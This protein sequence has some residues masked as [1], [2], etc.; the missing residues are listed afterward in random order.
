M[1]SYL[2]IRCAVLATIVF[3]TGAWAGPGDLHW[4]SPPGKPYN[5]APGQLLPTEIDLKLQ[6]GTYYRRGSYQKKG[7]P[8]TQDGIVGIIKSSKNRRIQNETG[9]MGTIVVD[10]KE[11]IKANGNVRL[12]Y[13]QEDKYQNDF[14]LKEQAKHGLS[15]VSDAEG[16]SRTVHLG[17]D[18]ILDIEA[19]NKLS[20]LAGIY[21]G[22]GG[23]VTYSRISLTGTETGGTLKSIQKKFG[24]W[25][26]GMYFKGG[27][28][29]STNGTRLKNNMTFRLGVES[30]GA[31]NASS[32][33][34]FGVAAVSM[35]IK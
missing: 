6:V 14:S 24:E 35:D 15:K 32:P 31:S 3:S 27:I 4:T 28:F 11:F 10:P 1:Q 29:V 33:G 34:T 16:K 12:G 30:A 2:Y 25:D 19:L 23:E 9:I 18:L 20:W 8:D 26:S 13:S 7:A 17:Y 5:G 21:V 22:G